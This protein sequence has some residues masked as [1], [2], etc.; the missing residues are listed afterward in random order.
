MPLDAPGLTWCILIQALSACVQ[1]G[2]M[3]LGTGL[4]VHTTVGD[5]AFGSIDSANEKLTG[6]S[7]S[8]IMDNECKY[9][10]VIETTGWERLLIPPSVQYTPKILN[11]RKLRN[12]LNLNEFEKDFEIFM[13]DEIRIKARVCHLFSASEESK[14]YVRIVLGHDYIY[15]SDGAPPQ[16]GARLEDMRRYGVRTKL[17]SA[18]GSS[19]RIRTRR[20]I[21]ELGGGTLFPRVEGAEE[22]LRE[23]DEIQR[24]L[25]AMRRVCRPPPMDEATVLKK[26]SAWGIIREQ[27]FQYFSQNDGELSGHN[28]VWFSVPKATEA[29]IR[30]I[31][32]RYN[33]Q[34]GDGSVQSYTFMASCMFRVRL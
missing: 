5:A 22:M 12:K 14:K 3:L 1:I 24:L 16:L 23:Y 34:F 2:K 8:M 17:N 6:H 31:K 15:F 9:H 13:R 32:T 26:M 28:F 27:E 10:C 25:P 11:D 30:A 18:P 7:F 33:E 21:E 29:H 19:F 4:Q 20:F